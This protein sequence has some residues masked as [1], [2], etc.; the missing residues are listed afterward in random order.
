MK[1]YEVREKD[2]FAGVWCGDNKAQALDALAKAHGFSS[3][4]AARDSEWHSFEF[5]IVEIGNTPVIYHD[6]CHSALQ[7]K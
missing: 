2:I 5:T 6:A 1:R 3:F 7:Q 4:Q